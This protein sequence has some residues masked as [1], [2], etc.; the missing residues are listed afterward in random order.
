MVNSDFKVF[1]KKVFVVFVAGVLL[2]FLFIWL[3]PSRFQ[4]IVNNDGLFIADKLFK[5][6]KVVVMK[7][8]DSPDWQ[9]GAKGK[10]GKIIDFK[11]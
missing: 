1:I 2:L 3:H 9:Y 4:I 5:N 7:T 10:V 11:F 8:T 6:L